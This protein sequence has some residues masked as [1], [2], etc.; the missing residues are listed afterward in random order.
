MNETQKVKSKQ[1]R[2]LFT[3]QQ[4]DIETRL[5][6]HN[7]RRTRPL[8]LQTRLKQT[9]QKYKRYYIYRHER[10]ATRLM[11]DLK[12]SRWLASANSLLGTTQR[13]IPCGITF[14]SWFRDLPSSRHSFRRPHT[15]LRSLTSHSHA[16]IQMTYKGACNNETF[17]YNM[18]TNAT[19]G[20]R[21]TGIHIGATEMAPAKWK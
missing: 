4:T 12:D 20:A 14:N 21:D 17:I 5:D 16:N 8:Q 6:N 15:S 1:Q 18:F 13:Q 11:R 3:E 19:A 10:T 2:T 9:W 7:R